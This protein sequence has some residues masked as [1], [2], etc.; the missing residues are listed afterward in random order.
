[1]DIIMAILVLL[2]VL[3]EVACV[4]CFKEGKYISL[5]LEYGYKRQGKVSI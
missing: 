1:M 2:H 3:V 5:C 4:T